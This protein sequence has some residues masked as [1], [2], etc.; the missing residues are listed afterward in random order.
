MIAQG[1]APTIVDVRTRAEF[2]RGHVP[3]AVHIPFQ[4]VGARASE[5]AA[6]PEDPVV[7]Y[8]GHGPRAWIAARTLRARG[9][10]RVM[11]LK[12]HWAAWKQARAGLY[13]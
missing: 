12:G 7:V 3:G 6:G 11:Y 10:Q 2:A 5:I 13:D 9:F 1:T 8:C 4:S